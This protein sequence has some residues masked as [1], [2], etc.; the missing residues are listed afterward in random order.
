[1]IITVEV[2]VVAVVII[3]LLNNRGKDLSMFY[4]M[5]RASEPLVV[6]EFTSEPITDADF[7]RF[8]SEWETLHAGPSPFTL[9]FDTTRM[10]IPHPKYSIKMALFIKKIRRIEPQRLSRSLIVVQSRTIA[11]LLE[12]VFYLQPP[13][14]PVYLTRGV[15]GA[16]EAV[17]AG[18]LDRSVVPAQPLPFEVTSVIQP[19]EPVLWF[20]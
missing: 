9:L 3:I 15:T 19:G 2:A 16:V 20:L 10:A 6:F 13:V 12:L 18:E 1:M 8:L 4:R 17:L 11:S 5:R 14:A 7:A